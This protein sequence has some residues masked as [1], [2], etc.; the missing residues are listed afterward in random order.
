MKNFAYPLLMLLIGTAG[1]LFSQPTLTYNNTGLVVGDNFTVHNIDISGL[2]AGNAGA[3]QTWDFSSA[4]S[5]GTTN[6]SFVDP[7]TAPNGSSFPTANLATSQNSVWDFYLTTS[8]DHARVGADN[9][10]QLVDYSASQVQLVFPMGYQDMYVDSFAATLS[11]AFPLDRSGTITVEA[12]GWGTLITP[13]GTYQN[14]LRIKYVEDY[15]DEFNGTPFAQYNSEIYTWYQPGTHYPIFSMTTF[16]IAGSSTTSYGGY[17]D[18]VSVSR[19]GPNHSDIQLTAYPNPASEQVTVAANLGKPAPLEFSLINASG[20][21][22]WE[23]Q[24]PGRMTEIREEISL[25]DLPAGIY[26][27]QVRS[28]EQRKIKKVI[29]Q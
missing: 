12:D 5:N 14:V 28:N 26:L 11:G 13:D 2:T 19:S 1:N 18:A 17:L 27:L 9:G 10:A 21:S 24:V 6:V 4:V 22:V 16:T 23:R 15:G 20:A 3:N 25:R 29:V 8:S 7:A